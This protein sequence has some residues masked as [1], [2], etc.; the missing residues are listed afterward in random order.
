MN[1]Y[2][3]NVTWFSPREIEEAKLRRDEQAI[4]DGRMFSNKLGQSDYGDFSGEGQKTNRKGH[5]N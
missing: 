5:L 1:E 4:A 2:P 3:Q